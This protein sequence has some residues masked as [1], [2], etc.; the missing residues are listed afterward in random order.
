MAEGIRK[1]VEVSINAGKLDIFKQVAARFIEKA[2][3]EPGTLSYEWFLNTDGSRCSI[4]ELYQ[5]SEALLIHLK[6]VRDL[7]EPLFEVS[8]LT[9]VD[10]FGDSN[11]EVREA[12]LP[13]TNFYTHWDGFTR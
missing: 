9:R 10:V 3:T 7:Y 11:A 2:N 8:Q 12:H 13:G 6:N 1:V 4:L 5:D